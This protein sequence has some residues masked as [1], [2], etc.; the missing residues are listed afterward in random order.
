MPSISTWIRT[1]RHLRARQVYGRLIHRYYRPQV[2]LATT[3]P[4][5]P[6]ISPWVQPIEKPASV[7]GAW[8][9]RFLN[10]SREVRGPSDWDKPEWDKLWRYNL[11]YFD[12]LCALGASERRS[13]HLDWMH[14]WVLENRPFAGTAWESYPTSLRIVNWIK[15]DLGGGG[16]PEQCVSSLSVQ[17][18]W[19]FRRLETHLLGNHLLANAKA[20]IFAGL[21][22]EGREAD[23]WLERGLSILEQEIAEQILPD[24]GHFERSPMYHSIILED[25]LDVLNAAN[26]F[27][28]HADRISETLRPVIG[29]MRRWL[30]AMLHPDGEISFFNDAAIGI[31]PAGAELEAYASRLGLEALPPCEAVILLRDSGYCRMSRA[32][33]MVLLADA[34]DI[35]PDYLPGHAHADT[36]SFELSV[37]GKR[38]FVNSGTSC[39]GV[40]PERL[41]QRG[42]AAHNTV[43]VDGADS[44]EVWSG[45]RVGK[46]ARASLESFAVKEDCVELGASH[47]GYAG[48]GHPKRYH[49]RRWILRDQALVIEDRITGQYQSA[50][51]RFHLSPQARIRSLSSDGSRCDIELGEDA[52]VLSAPRGRISVEDAT[53]HPEF[54]V[55]IPSSCICV[56]VHDGKS[57]VEV[58]WHGK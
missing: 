10:T 16:L 49:H 38:L 7:V 14:R 29:R 3:L 47:D 55:S 5:R 40:S 13:F 6:G 4:R 11:H 33:D 24:G 35:G 53:W 1:L 45:F 58:S 42:T 8:V 28:I 36:L 27:S 57:T 34:G 51:A 12:D 32:R 37:F 21:F 15:W 18:R 48:R 26:V 9:F 54:G 56:A 22:F 50:Q 52:V 43:I 39:Y 2:D 44:S 23:A 19:L 20:L 41:R 46:R 30:A 31:A 17:A 25:L